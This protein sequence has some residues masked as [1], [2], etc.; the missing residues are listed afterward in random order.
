[1]IVDMTLVNSEI[2][3]PTCQRAKLLPGL[4]GVGLTASD[5]VNGKQ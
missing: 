1:M 3:F 2:K 4:M 5:E